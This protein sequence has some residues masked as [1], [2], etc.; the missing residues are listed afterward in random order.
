MGKENKCYPVIPPECPV[1]PLANYVLSSQIVANNAPA[2]GASF[3]GVRFT[4]SSPVNFQVANQQLEFFVSGSAALIIPTPYTNNN[5]VLDVAATNTEPETVQL[6]ASLSADPT[7]SANSLLTFIPTGPQPTYELT[8]RRI[9]NDAYANG[10]SI[11]QVEFYLT[12][13]GASVSGQLRLYFNGSFTELVTTA[14]NGLYIASFSSTEPGS[15]VVRAEVESNRSVFAS[16]TVTFIPVAS[17]PIYLGS[18]LVVIPLN[19]YMGIESLISP[20]E[21]IAGHTYRIENIATGWSTINYCS[22]YAFEQSNQACSASRIPDFIMLLQTGI[23]QVHVRAS[24]SGQGVDL[25]AT[26]RY[27]WNRPTVTQFVV[28]VYDDGPD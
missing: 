8:S 4:L 11:N 1:S 16:E 25:R 21:F 19:F 18:L 10:T 13:G 27:Y 26:V 22:N 20:F 17:Y 6:F 5:G 24:N 3:N 23:N 2:D 12:Y 28:Q 14:P 9:V 15:F 7:V